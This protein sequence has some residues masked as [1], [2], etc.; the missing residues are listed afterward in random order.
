MAPRRGA[1]ID[2]EVTPDV[3]EEA[4]SVVRSMRQALDEW[5][6]R[7][8]EPAI[9]TP[10]PDSCKYCDFKHDCA[11]FWEAAVAW[12]ESPAVVEVQV[13]GS[14]QLEAGGMMYQIRV[15]KA[16]RDLSDSRF[17]RRTAVSN[18]CLERLPKPKPTKASPLQ[19]LL[20]DSCNMA[21]YSTWRG[22]LPS[23]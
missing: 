20:M 19:R 17:L 7:L 9:A 8:D 1:I 13:T 23:S 6:S 15:M 3:R 10:S 5:N 21:R 2:W 16:T 18:P 12:A 4:V 11:P 22:G 14:R